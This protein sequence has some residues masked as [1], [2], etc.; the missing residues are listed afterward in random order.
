MAQGLITTQPNR[1]VLATAKERLFDRLKGHPKTIPALQEHL[2]E[3][4]HG[5]SLPGFH[6]P[7]REKVETLFRGHQVERNAFRRFHLA[8]RRTAVIFPSATTA[9]LLSSKSTSTAVL[10]LTSS[11]PIITT[12]PSTSIIAPITAITAVF[13]LFDTLRFGWV[14]GPG[15]PKIQIGQIESSIRLGIR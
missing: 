9:T 11:A 13:K 7:L 8:T 1:L 14:T 2:G 5:E 10:P 4:K 15:W 3:I 6:H 12:S